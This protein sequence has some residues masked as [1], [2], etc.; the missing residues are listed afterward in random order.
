MTETLIKKEKNNS[1]RR[2]EEENEKE[3]KEEE[4]EG[5]EEVEKEEEE[6]TKK[7]REGVR[8]RKRV[9]TIFNILRRESHHREIDDRLVKQFLSVMT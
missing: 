7:R 5:F 4:G 6:F 1:K 3:E 2:E 8:D 9:L